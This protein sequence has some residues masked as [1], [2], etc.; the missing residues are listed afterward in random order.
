MRIALATLFSLI[1]SL[2]VGCADH[3]THQ[4]LM[5]IS[6]YVSDEPLRALAAL[7]SLDPGT[8]TTADRHYRD[9]LRIKAADKAY[10]RHESDSLVLDVI[11]YYSENGCDEMHAEALYYG[12]RVY[13]DLGDYP[14]ALRYF[15]EALDIMPKDEN[16]MAR[17]A[18][19]SSQC[20][21]LLNTLR[22]YDEAKPYIKSAIETGMRMGDTVNV[23]YDLQLLGGVYLRSYE[24]DAAERTFQKALHLSEGRQPYHK[25]KSMM[26]LAAIKHNKGRI[27][28]ALSLIRGTPDLVKPTVRNS[29]LGYAANIYLDAG[30]LDTAYMYSYELVNS[31]KP[32][33][34]ESGY[35]VLLSP[36]MRKLVPLDS[37]DVFISGYRSLLETYYEEDKVQLAINQESLYN[38]RIH[39]RDKA[40]AQQKNRI[41]E[42][43]SGCLT[44]ILFLSISTALYLKN[45][46]RAK[47][48]ELQDALDNIKKMKS[49][50]GWA[51][52]DSSDCGMY[53][54]NSCHRRDSEDAAHVYKMGLADREKALRQKI[55]DEIS[56]LCE[57]ADMTPEIPAVFLESEV[58]HKLQDTIAKGA[59]IPV[60]SGIWGEIEFMV[61]KVSTKFRDD[62]NMLTSGR[63]TIPELHTAYLIK[64][65]LKPIQI[66]VLLGR[67]R[68]AIVSRRESICEKITG[69]RLG[70]H[71]ADVIIHLL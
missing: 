58:Y 70:A 36:K 34:R 21:R 9:F 43:L 16:S 29:A 62:L 57:K 30:I 10:I 8:L 35:Q 50:M 54:G 25:A 56:T 37:L 4:T 20:G 60:D 12:G 64:C 42:Y 63:L 71:V 40:I 67:S 47:I 5:E 7:D 18:D 68:G 39:E 15:H 59:S 23:I 65:G 66:S 49:R 13:S 51:P 26:Y 11:G 1:L 28:S 48:I 32:G 44:L 31:A 33:P 52:A 22:L 41:M 24:Y 38:Y 53:G 61:Q 55:K 3:P 19:I 2:S 6:G 45:R 46:Y 17:R 69:E 14:T 27:D